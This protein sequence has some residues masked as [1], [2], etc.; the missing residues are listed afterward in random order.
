MHKGWFT[1]KKELD[2]DQKEFI[3][4]P[5]HGRYSLIGPPGSGKTNLLLLR[6][7]Y[8]AGTGEKNVLII[9]YTKAL[10]DFIRSGISTQGLIA[11][12]QVKTYHAWALEHILQYLGHRAIEKGTEFDEAVRGNILELV[13][14][15]NSKSPAKKLY[16]G[17]F[18][19]E[20]QDLTSA[21][22]ESLLSLS[23]NVC[24]CGDSRQGIY[25]RNGLDV[26]SKLGLSQYV[27]TRH[28]RIGQRI[29]RVADRLIPPADGQEGLEATSN[30][31]AKDHGESSARMHP[32]ES[33][34][35]QFKKMFDL[36][37]V[38]LDAFNGESIGIV[39]GTREALADV[40]ARFASTSLA[41]KI[42]VH[43]LDADSSFHGER[44][45]HALTIHAAKGTEFRAVHMFATED[46]LTFPLNRT[47]LAYTAITRAR[48]ALNAYRTGETNVALENAFTEPTH[49]DLD[50]LLPE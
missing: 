43:G 8:I 46:L 36:I 38:Q 2:D 26:A 40:K 13:K 49:F 9:T 33:R 10:A 41:D 7:Q 23:D 12:T 28:F 30:Y 17:I 25:Q 21:E 50:A 27:L 11:P 6:A 4:L 35:A 24:I 22:L 34:D 45:I 19:D 42:A 31:N 14:E 29:A 18:V 16:S 5:A 39:C 47:K 3:M 37:E 15:A 32:C 20:A 44:P 48:T 1:S